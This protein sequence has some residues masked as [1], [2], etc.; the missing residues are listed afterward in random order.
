MEENMKQWKKPIAEVLVISSAD[1]IL[2]NSGNDP[3][4]AEDPNWNQENIPGL[5]Q[6]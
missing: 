5:K 2:L 3:F 6:Q 4:L 1:D